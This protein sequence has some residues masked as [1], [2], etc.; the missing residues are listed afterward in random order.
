MILFAGQSW[1]NL[2]LSKL[3]SHCLRI[4]DRIRPGQ[5]D[6]A[7]GGFYQKGN[8]DSIKRDLCDAKDD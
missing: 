8:I 7:P 5:N 3:K 6:F 2:L 1:K 4:F